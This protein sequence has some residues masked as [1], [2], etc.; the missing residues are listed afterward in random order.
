MT[1]HTVVSSEA[2]LTARKELLKKE[3]EFSRLQDELTQQRRDLPWEKV[4]KDY[5]FDGPNGS[6]SLAELFGDRSQ[7]IIYHFMF[8]PD[9]PAG[10]KICSMCADLYEP[11]AIHLKHR[12][13]S[14]ATVSRAPLATLEAYKRRMGWSF[15]WVSSLNNS[16][17][18][19]YNVSFTQADLDAG[20]ACYNY[21]KGVKFPATEG[22]GI[23]SFYK[24]DD[25]DVF[26]TYSSFGRGLENF[27]GIY[28]FLDIVTKGRDEAALPYGMAWVRHK[29]KYDDKTVIDP[30]AK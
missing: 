15:T 10:C 21:Q 27:L 25:G 22:P 4:E 14:L 8:G 16:F 23:S 20:S 11:M 28:K 9:W 18:W 12:D 2:W 17:N 24:A 7:L 6:E 29:D 1:D 3:K 5:V 30:Y 19:D 13:A 26:H